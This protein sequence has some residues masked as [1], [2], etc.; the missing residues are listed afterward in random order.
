MTGASWH[1][2]VR[3][4]GCA[5]RLDLGPF[6][7]FVA[8]YSSRGRYYHHGHEDLL[9]YVVY[10]HGQETLCDAGRPSYDPADDTFIG[11]GAHNGLSC[12]DQPLSPT[13]GVLVPAAFSRAT[14]NEMKDGDGILFEA[15]NHVF[16]SRR[17]LRLSFDSGRLRID[18]TFTHRRAAPLAF[19]HWFADANARLEPAGVVSGACRLHYESLSG[20][21]LKPAIRST[22]YGERLACTRLT[23][24]PDDTTVTTWLSHV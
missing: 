3:L 22:E 1:A 4:Q 9:S 7:L 21:A 17:R 20:I 19:T 13:P 8:T 6:T 18:E 23:A 2:Q 10:T 14:V 12:L 24:R 5:R 16:G 15:T 11:A